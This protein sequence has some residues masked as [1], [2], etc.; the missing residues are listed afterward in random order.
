MRTEALHF[1][2]GGR[3]GAGGEKAHRGVSISWLLVV[4]PAVQAVGLWGRRCHMAMEDG[5]ASVPGLLEDPREVAW[6]GLV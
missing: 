4:F 3:A 2:E 1:R 5:Q 6:W